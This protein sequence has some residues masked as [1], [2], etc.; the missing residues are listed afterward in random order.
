MPSY[1]VSLHS[2][3]RQIMEHLVNF[4]KS[5][6]AVLLLEHPGSRLVQESFQ[7]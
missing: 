2:V 3:M 1:Q 7:C 5:V 4:S 6:S